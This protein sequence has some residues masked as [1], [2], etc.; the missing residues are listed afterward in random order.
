MVQR[1]LSQSINVDGI[2]WDGWRWDSN[3][4]TYSFPA[5]PAGSPPAA[6]GFNTLNAA[7]Q[8][9]ARADAG[10]LPT[11]PI[12]NRVSGNCQPSSTMEET[13]G[14]VVIL[15]SGHRHQPRT[16]AETALAVQPLCAANVVTIGKTMPPSDPAA[17]DSTPASRQ[18][19]ARPCCRPGTFSDAF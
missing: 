19:L 4:I 18:R 8:A 12:P 15:S 14:E 16:G 5:N 9:A 17:A 6:E 7:Q 13:M 1:V 11:P 10:A 3:T 2:L